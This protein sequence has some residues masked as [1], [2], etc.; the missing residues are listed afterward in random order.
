AT[1]FALRRLDINEMMNR[2]KKR[3]INKGI[4]P[5]PA[6]M[7]LRSGFANR[8]QLA[9]HYGAQTALFNEVSG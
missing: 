5:S 2:L 4:S 9:L 8:L 3:I 1:D 7:C 6:V